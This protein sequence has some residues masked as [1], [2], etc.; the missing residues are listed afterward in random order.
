M[1]DPQAVAR[2]GQWMTHAGTVWID[3]MLDEHLLNAYNTAQRHGNAKA[4]ELLRE[5]EHRNLD[6][7]INVKAISKGR[8]WQSAH[9]PDPARTHI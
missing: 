5:I 8:R 4:D 7:R 3:D 9:R 2:R 1:N 6:W